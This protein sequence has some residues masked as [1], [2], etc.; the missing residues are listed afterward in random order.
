MRSQLKSVLTNVED[1]GM[2]LKD[3]K[4]LRVE[5]ETFEHLCGF[6]DSESQVHKTKIIQKIYILI[7]LG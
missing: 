1:G 4:H 6:V 2:R 7:W 5:V 3:T